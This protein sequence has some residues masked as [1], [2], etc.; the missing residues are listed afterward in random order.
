VIFGAAVEDER[1]WHYRGRALPL[2]VLF[3]LATSSCATPPAAKLPTQQPV[4]A[5]AR[6]Q[7]QAPPAPVP[8]TPPIV[9]EPVDDKIPTVAW[10]P[11]L[12]RC[13]KE[14]ALIEDRVCIDRWEASLVLRQGEG[15]GEGEW[16]PFQPIDGVEST[17]RAVSKADT[18]PQGYISGKQAMVACRASGKRLCQPDEWVAACMGPNH[19]TYPYGNSRREGVC[20]D[21]VRAV[22]P[23]AEIGIKLGIPREEWWTDAMNHPLI[24]QLPHSLSTTGS[25]ARCTNGYGVFDMVGNLHEW[26]DDPDGT[27]RGGYYMDTLKNGDGCKYRTTAHHARYHDYST[28]FRCCAEPEPVE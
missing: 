5:A 8:P 1:P 22:H 14:M 19:T 3:A 24:N 7:S 6:L 4:Q 21:S 13:P 16:S 25:H 20:N 26:V 11:E 28:G 23:V 17:V 10:E 12:I 9:A 27:F 15:E 18:L 2:G